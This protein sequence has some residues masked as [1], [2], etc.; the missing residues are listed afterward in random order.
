MDI[1]YPYYFIWVITFKPEAF[2]WVRKNAEKPP[3]RI[4]MGGL[5]RAVHNRSFRHAMIRLYS[6]TP[7]LFLWSLR[8]FREERHHNRK[9]GK[10]KPNQ[11]CIMHA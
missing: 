7:P 2:L 8:T 11:K 10:N 6:C 3:I 5:W 9:Q 4:R 1:E